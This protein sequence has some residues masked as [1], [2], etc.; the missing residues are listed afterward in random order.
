MAKIGDIYRAEICFEDNPNSSKTRP[1]LI[2]GDK[3]DQ[4]LYLI[5]EI[6]SVPPHVPP[7]YHDR[8][9]EPINKWVQAGLGK[10]SWVKTHKLNRVE[11]SAFQSFYG[12][13]D[14]Q[15]LHDIS[16]KVVQLHT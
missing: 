16:L 7:K 1:V 12:E 8:F 3:D 11:E 2:L 5:V 10:P 9:K 6:T 14:S 4:G 13:L 15:E